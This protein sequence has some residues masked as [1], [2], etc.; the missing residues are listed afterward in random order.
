MPS[1]LKGLMLAVMMAALMSSLTSIF[2]SSSTI[3]TLDVWTRFRSKPS[4]TELLIVG[5][6]FVIILV[7]ISIAW[8]PIITKFKSSQLFVYIQV[9]RQ[10]LLAL[11]SW[12]IYNHRSVAAPL[13]YSLCLI[14][15][16]RKKFVQLFLF[17]HYS[18]FVYTF[19][20]LTLLLT[21]KSN[22]KSFYLFFLPGYLQLPLTTSRCYFPLGILLAENQ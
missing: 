16:S 2:N 13:M 1:G 18:V 11:S 6:S 4:E 10:S 3:F 19:I 22:K 9:L 20:I 21:T 17:S 15:S 8:I 12:S 5:R 14:W 7:A